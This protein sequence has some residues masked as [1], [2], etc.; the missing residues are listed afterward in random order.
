MAVEIEVTAINPAIARTPAN[1]LAQTLLGFKMA[2]IGNSQGTNELLE[3]RC[4]IRRKR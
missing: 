4:C 2:V 1:P 3:S